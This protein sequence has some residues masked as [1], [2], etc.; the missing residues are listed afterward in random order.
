[1]VGIMRNDDFM[2]DFQDGRRLLNDLLSGLAAN[3]GG[4][5]HNIVLKPLIFVNCVS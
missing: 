5:L 2:R 3:L 1:M 4:M